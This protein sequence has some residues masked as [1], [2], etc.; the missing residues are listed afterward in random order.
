MDQ[1]APT[2]F[3]TQDEKDALYKKNKLRVSFYKVL[4]FSHIADGI[5]SGHLNVLHSYKY[6]AIHE[7]LIDEQV[8]ASERKDLLERAGLTHFCDFQATMNKFKLQLDSK[9]KVVNERFLSGQNT[10]LKIDK[11]GKVIIGVASENGKNCTL[12]RFR[13]WNPSVQSWYGYSK[14]FSNISRRYA[15]CQQLIGRFNLAVGHFSFPTTL[16]PQ[17]ACYC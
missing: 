16:T 9:Y 12:S 13:C 1:K 4:L 14:V 11:N 5:K 2:D 6:R 7:Y 10:H 15:I 3:L 17:L 8:W